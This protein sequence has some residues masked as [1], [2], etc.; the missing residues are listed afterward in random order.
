MAWV[1]LI[2]LVVIFLTVIAPLMRQR[3]VVA[4]RT[5]K[6]RRPAARREARS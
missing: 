3:S 1:V 5:R 4:A 6:L 2:V